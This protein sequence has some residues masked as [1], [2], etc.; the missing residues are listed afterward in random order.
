MRHQEMDTIARQVL[1]AWRTDD[2]DTFAQLLA[3]VARASDCQRNPALFAHVLFRLAM[4]ETRTVDKES[5]TQFLTSA[6]TKLRECV[7]FDSALAAVLFR[8]ALG[9]PQL[10]RDIPVGLTVAL[11]LAFAALQLEDTSD[12]RL[13]QLLNE[14]SRLAA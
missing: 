14:A 8:G 7:E 2:R 1:H 12:D 3:D 5:V 13:E 4:R 9:A 10:L 11:E 6:T